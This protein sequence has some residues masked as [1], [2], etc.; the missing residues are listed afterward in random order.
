[1]FLSSF[2]SA[3]SEFILSTPLLVDMNY[4]YLYIIFGSVICLSYLA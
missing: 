1:M 4:S 3:F 2:F